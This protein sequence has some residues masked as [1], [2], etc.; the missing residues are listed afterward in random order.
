MGEKGN[1]WNLI[2]S[3]AWK[4]SPG[5][6]GPWT[7]LRPRLF[8]RG[9]LI[10]EIAAVSEHGSLVVVVV[11]MA[12]RPVV[13][14]R[15]RQLSQVFPQLWLTCQQFAASLN[16]GRGGC[17]R[18]GRRGVRPW[19]RWC[20]GT[21]DHG[22]PVA[23]VFLVGGREAGL[24]TFILFSIGLPFRASRQILFFNRGRVSFL[25]F[26]F[27]RSSRGRIVVTVVV[28]IIIIIFSLTRITGEWIYCR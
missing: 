20:M 14:L 5:R 17:R 11:M 24:E 19:R 13:V 27:D 28:V 8:P 15:E 22:V 9:L 4:H 26:V 2:V 25:G 21:R 7:L 10:R 3:Q 16:C 23:Q 1:E 18:G 12:G 6:H